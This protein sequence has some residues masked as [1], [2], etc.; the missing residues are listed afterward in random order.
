LEGNIEYRFDIVK[1]LKGALFLDAGNIWLMK[2]DPIGEENG[3]DRSGGVFHRKTFLN[4][5]A[6]GSGLGLRFDF[7]FFVL[8]LDVAFPLRKP[9]LIDD[10]WVVDDVDFG[11]KTWRKDNLVFNIA[12]GYPF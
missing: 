8:R 2:A 6:V 11:S 7:S 5:L 1:L 3:V 9:Y 12:I 10:P 4:E